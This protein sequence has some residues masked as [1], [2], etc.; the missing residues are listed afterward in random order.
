MRHWGP[1]VRRASAV[2]MSDGPRPLDLHVVYA[3]DSRLSS[4][5]GARRHKRSIPVTENE[6]ARWARGTAMSRVSCSAR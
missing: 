1:L 3:F 4:Q 5:I 6:R 2:M